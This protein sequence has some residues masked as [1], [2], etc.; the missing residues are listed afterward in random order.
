[1]KSA[2]AAVAFVL[3]VSAMPA[4]KDSEFK[5][6]RLIKIEEIPALAEV[7]GTSYKRRCT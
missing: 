6:G 3:C 4:Q 7:G 1:M 2:F 5:A